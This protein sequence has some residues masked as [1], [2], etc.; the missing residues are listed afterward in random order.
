MTGRP[1][2]GARRSV[3]VNPSRLPFLVLVLAA[4]AA[5]GGPADDSRPRL[6]HLATQQEIARAPL[7]VMEVHDR[8]APAEICVQLQLIEFKLPRGDRV[9]PPGAGT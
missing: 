6:V 3:L 8:L 4:L 7:P 5:C 9:D 1:G 2:R